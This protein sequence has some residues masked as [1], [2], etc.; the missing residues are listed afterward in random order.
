MIAALGVLVMSG[1]GRIGFDALDA[2]NQNAV[3]AGAQIDA[4]TS[5]CTF[6]PWSAP[7]LLSSVS[8][9]SDDWGPAL[10]PD[11]LTMYIE[12][13]RPPDPTLWRTTR[14]SVDAMW[15]PA[16]RV[17]GLDE[18][19]AYE[20]NPTILRDGM[21]LYFTADRVTADKFDLYRA[22]RSAPS[23]EF[24]D[25]VIVAELTR[26]TVLG[27]TLSS[28]GTELIFT[29]GF[30]NPNF[31]RST[32]QDGVFGT[33]TSIDE[34]NTPLGEGWGSLGDDLTMIFTTDRS[35]DTGLYMTTRTAIG[36]PWS[37]PTPI[38]ELNLPGSEET[39]PDFSADMLEVIF[40]SDRAGGIGSFDLYS[41]T[42]QCD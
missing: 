25:E 16:T 40:A 36:A 23:A 19:G 9:S 4:G 30:T 11:R 33:T 5:G 8:T 26:E 13:N 15:E 24:A 20:S 42:R 1:C 39:D 27:P 28:D 6:G 37:S 32:L 38:A 35:G 29:D 21:T 7:L 10:S 31:R 12:T 3:D 22:T 18:P 34:L 14:S 41:S 17:A 2:S